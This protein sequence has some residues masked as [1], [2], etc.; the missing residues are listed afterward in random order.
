MTRVADLALNDITIPA[1]RMRRLRPEVVAELAES[2]AARG[3]LH[4]IIVRHWHTRFLLVA[5]H[6][7]VEAVQTLGHDKIRAVILD[8]LD[9]D[10][11]LLA[12]IDENLIRADLSPAERAL[13][14]AERKRLYLKQHPQTA[15]VRVRGGPGRG[16]KNESQDAT[17]F[18]PAFIDDTAKRTGKHRATIAREVARAKI[19]AL[20]DVPG[21]SLD[22]PD[23]LDALAKLPEPVQ[24]DLIMRAKSGEEVTAKHVAQKLRRESHEL[25]LA[26]ATEAASRTLGEK[27]YGVIYADPPWRFQVYA[28]SGMDL[29][30]DNHYPTMPTE[31]IKQIE[32]PAADNCAL[33]LWATV[34]LLPQC[35]DVMAAW[36]FSYKSLILWEKDRAGTGYWTRN[37]V[38]ILLIGARGNIP[39]PTPGEQP[40]Q[41]IEAPRGRHSEKPT[42][43][44]ETIERLYPHTPKLEMFA[45]TARP[46]WDAWGNEVNSAIPDDL[47]IPLCLM[48][49]S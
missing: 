4:A 20:A 31:A 19:A 22:Q 30:A 39:A 1:D 29:L 8:G 42:V 41:V 9:A 26:T 32:V 46:G 34:P 3:L 5:G 43:F 49:A 18:A 17:G 25:E 33:F 14:L 15:S 37:T 38:E 12:E 2:I 13:H 23:E 48:R 44:A 21:T 47:S 10:A 7:R 40:P 45:R 6:H 16:K 35:L 11:A 36:G 27:L 28:E 24:R